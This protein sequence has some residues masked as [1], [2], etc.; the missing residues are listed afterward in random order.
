MDE[1]AAIPALPASANGNV[2]APGASVWMEDG[3]REGRTMQE[4]FS[5]FHPGF[6]LL[7]L[8]LFALLRLPIPKLTSGHGEEGWREPPLE[9]WL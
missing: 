7:H 6:L 5:C 2:Q 3:G 1:A 4:G 8:H 9:F